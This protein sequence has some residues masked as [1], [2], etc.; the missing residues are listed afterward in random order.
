G[1]GLDTLTEDNTT[2]CYAVQ[3]K[4]W[5]HGPGQEPWEVYAVKADSV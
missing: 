3:D 5:I 1:A 4:V 2:C